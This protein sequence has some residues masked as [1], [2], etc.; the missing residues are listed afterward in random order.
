MEQIRKKSVSIMAKL[1]HDTYTVQPMTW[2]QAKD[3][4]LMSF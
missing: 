3:Y 4:K 2:L 1:K